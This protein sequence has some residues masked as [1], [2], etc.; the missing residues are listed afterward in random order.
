MDAAGASTADGTTVQLAHCNGGPAQQFRLNTRHDLVSVLA[1]KC[2]D[3]RDKRTSNGARL[4]LW[5][6][7]GTP[8]QKW[9]KN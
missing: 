1:D 3:V 7:A 8:N 4:Q 6:C 5:A 2:V 9:S